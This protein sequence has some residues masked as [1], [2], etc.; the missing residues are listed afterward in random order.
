MLT[1]RNA[2]YTL[3]ISRIFH[4]V[5]IWMQMGMELGLALDFYLKSRGFNIFIRLKPDSALVIQQGIGTPPKMMYIN[6]RKC[7]FN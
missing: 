5:K 1:Y 4:K 6:W 2:A 3:V 7:L